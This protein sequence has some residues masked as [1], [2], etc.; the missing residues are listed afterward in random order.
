M[1]VGCSAIGKKKKYACVIPRLLQIIDV[2][3]KGCSRNVT[4]RRESTNFQN[5]IKKFHLTMFDNQ[6]KK[7]K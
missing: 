4:D 2:F 1:E 3:G 5:M 7:S 6:R